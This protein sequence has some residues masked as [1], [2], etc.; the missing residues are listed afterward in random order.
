MN[1]KEAKQEIIN[2][3][4]AYF[5][6]DETGA[7]RIPLE[8][9]RPLLLMGPPG[10]GKTAIMEQAAAELGINLL[11]YTITHHTRQ[12]AIG[13]P[14]IA[15]RVFGG[16]EYSV[17]EYTMSEIIASI[18]EKIECSGVKEGILFLD[19]INCVSE[20]LSPTMLRFLQYK[21]FGM[22][23]LPE[24]FMIVAAGN[25]PEYNK[26]VRDFDIVTLD[27]I[28][29]IDVSEDFPSFKEYAYRNGVHGSVLAYLEI[30]KDHFYSVKQE[31][32]GKSFVT[33]RGW[34]DLSR[35]IQAYEEMEI[36]VTEDLIKEYVRDEEIARSFSVYYELYNKYRNIY[37]IPDILSGD[38][39][40]GSLDLVSA[41]FDE[42]LSV[43]SLLVD[44]LNQEA[45][46]YADNLAIQKVIFSTIKE[47]G[48]SMKETPDNGLPRQELCNRDVRDGV[49]YRDAL[50]RKTGMME[51]ELRRKSDAG[52]L[53]REDGHNMKMAIKELRN[54]LRLMSL[55]EQGNGY[56]AAKE[57]FQKREEDRQ[58]NIRSTNS[59]LSNAFSFLDTTFGEGQEL[60]IFLSELS[61]GYYT[62][63]FVT[64]C[65]NDAYYHY[66][67]FLLLHDR[68][69]EL[70]Q[71]ALKIFDAF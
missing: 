35:I 46:E 41:P 42:K 19:E 59:H 13:L 9:Q 28:R 24:G 32:D 65:G 22:H 64:E 27:R 67:K 38:F 30:R 63:K 53:T 66:N 10:I 23:P 21:T 6:K 71:E 2:S 1:I 60:V 56:E 29:R 36:P 34:E 37:R 55:D 48:D 15:K 40:K 62:L 20:T 69:E 61:A 16:K 3:A 11:S 5:R 51:E 33:A 7:Y 4:R 52:M 68:R 43:L 18:Y 54:L 17:T 31:L 12:S 8:K 25:P 70:R 44:T 47:L 57:W 49:S 45:R 39:P 26:S 14:F 58:A 50:Y